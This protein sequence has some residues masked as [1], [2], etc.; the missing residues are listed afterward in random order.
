MCMTISLFTNL[1]KYHEAFLYAL[2]LLSQY[3][4]HRRFPEKGNAIKRHP[5]AGNWASDFTQ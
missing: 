3:V 4:L 2:T 1:G 5:H